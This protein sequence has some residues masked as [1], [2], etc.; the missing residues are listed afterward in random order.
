M[1]KKLPVFLSFSALLFFLFV[2]FTFV[3]PSS[4]ATSTHV[5]ISEIQIADATSSSSADFVEIYNPTNLPINIGDLRLVKRT[6]SG[7]S[8]SSLVSFTNSDIVPAHGY[9]L[10]C[11]SEEAVSTT[12]D[13]VTSA[14]IANNNSIALRQE[15]AQ[16]G[17]LIDAVTLGVVTNPLGEG[18]PL[19][20]PGSGQSVERK[21]QSSSTVASMT[22]GI[23]MI[24]GNGEDT[25]N[26]VVDFITRAL[27]QPQNTT[28]SAEIVPN[29]PT[30]TI[31]VSPTASVSPTLTPTMSPTPTASIT[32][33]LTLTPTPTSTVTPTPTATQTP[34]PTVS[35]TPTTTHTPTP[36]MSVTPSIQASPTATM[37]PTP[38][39]TNTLPHFQLVCTTKT[40][41]FAV[42]GRTFSVNYPLC[43][44]KRI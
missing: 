11:S 35:I 5:V 31:S 23:D 37:S 4:A 17:A 30:L 43:N 39:P 3:S 24:A 20:A 15:P 19:T 41:S 26:N 7:S 42:L 10:W 8:D 1:R 22:S 33:T 6:S 32:P 29:S 44:L 13:A 36:S 40:I 27:S 34:T 9:F 16:T 25:D 2:L 21:A 12:C 28:S 38:T 18:T 14:N